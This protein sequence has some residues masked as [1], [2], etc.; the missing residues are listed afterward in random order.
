M[1]GAQRG[2]LT[3]T[4]PQPMAAQHWTGRLPPIPPPLPLHLLPSLLFPPSPLRSLPPLLSPPRPPGLGEELFLEE[5]RDAEASQWEAARRGDWHCGWEGRWEGERRGPA[6][7]Q[8]NVGP[9][10]ERAGTREREGPA[11]VQP[12]KLGARVFKI[13][14]TV[15]FFTVPLNENPEISVKVT[16][17]LTA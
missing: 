13:P 6:V 2:V 8:S 11:S 9:G 7:N 16:Q 12:R 4:S 15:H 5:P 10:R 1:R 3:Q 14:A 17:R